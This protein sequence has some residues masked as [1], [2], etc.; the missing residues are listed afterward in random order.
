MTPDT[1]FK[2]TTFILEWFLYLRRLS[3]WSSGLQG[4]TWLLI[5]IRT[6]N[7]CTYWNSVNGKDISLVLYNPF[8]YFFRRNSIWKVLN[9]SAIELKLYNRFSLRPYALDDRTLP[10][11]TRKL[12]TAA[13]CFPQYYYRGWLSTRSSMASY[14]VVNIWYIWSLGVVK[15]VQLPNFFQVD[16]FFQED[17]CARSF[18]HL[19]C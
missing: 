8:L 2:K 13:R 15:I 10:G 18:K 9:P 12:I 17:A 7:M 4:C 11:I 6:R 14:F 19:L 1:W 16:V 5:I 3:Q